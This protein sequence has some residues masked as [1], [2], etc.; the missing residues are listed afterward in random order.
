M[1][2]CVH[3][4]SPL[5]LSFNTDRVE[6]VEADDVRGMAAMFERPVPGIRERLLEPDGSVR[7]YVN[8]FLTQGGKRSPAEASTPVQDD[9]EVRIVLGMPKG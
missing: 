8:V 4:P 7:D 2:I 6:T 3:V 1:A 5:G 9:T